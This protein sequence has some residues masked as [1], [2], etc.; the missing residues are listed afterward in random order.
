M[1]YAWSPDGRWMALSFERDRNTDIYLMS[2]DGSKEIRLTTDAA[3]DRSPQ[4]SPDSTRIAFIRYVTPEN[5]QIYV[6]NIDG[7]GETRLTDQSISYGS[8]EWQP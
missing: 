2:I 1:D 7:S 6:V 3:D 8:F 4:W 5:R